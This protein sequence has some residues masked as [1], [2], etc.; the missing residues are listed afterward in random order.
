MNVLL[1][2]ADVPYPQL[3]EMEQINPEFAPRTSC[4]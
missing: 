3:W 4:W 1:A 2:E